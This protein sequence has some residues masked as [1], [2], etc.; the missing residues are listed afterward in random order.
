MK[1][2]YVVLGFVFLIIGLIG[3]LL[4]VMPTIPFLIVSSAYFSISMP[5]IS[6]SF[7][8]A[9][10]SNSVQVGE[11]NIR[12]SEIIAEHIRPANEGVIS[13]PFSQYIW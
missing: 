4:P 5:A 12:V 6:A 10:L 2:L 13:T 3:L 1:K 7:V 11:R 8:A 9:S